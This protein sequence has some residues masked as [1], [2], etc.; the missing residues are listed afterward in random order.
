[1]SA[2]AADP[3]AATPAPNVRLDIYTSDYRVSGVTASRFTRVADIVNALND[4]YLAIAEATF[5]EHAQPK[6]TRTSAEVLVAL[7][8]ILFVI[9]PEVDG[10]ARPEMRIVKEAFL[11]EMA[12]PPFRIGGS[13][14]VFQHTRPIDGLLN[15]AERFVTIT[16]AEISCAAYPGLQR[17]A[18]A[19]AVQRA[20][21]HL[22]AIREDEG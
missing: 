20:R 4:G 10:A 5:T 22:V 7:E 13:M 17:S 3:F 6:V 16:E 18:S 15:T 19:V 1:M 14:H 11:V 8:E 9:A 21:A 12:L 2:F